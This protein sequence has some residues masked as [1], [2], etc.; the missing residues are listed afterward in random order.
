[1]TY[2]GSSASHEETITISAF[3]PLVQNVIGDGAQ[4]VNY[5]TFMIA[6]PQK[7]DENRNLCNAFSD[8]ISRLQDSIRD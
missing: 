6:M 3:C 8:K 1:M 5:F 2:I 4:C 7:R